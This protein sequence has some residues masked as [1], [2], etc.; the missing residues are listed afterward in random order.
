V[1]G[2]GF[3][4]SA[5]LKVW[6]RRALGEATSSR[7]KPSQT[8]C[9]DLKTV[10]LVD[11]MIRKISLALLLLSGW[12]GMTALAAE[13]DR[14]SRPDYSEVRELIQT[15]LPEV[16]AAQ[17]DDA[18]VRGL[19]EA[20][21]GK[22]RLVDASAGAA[23]G[24]TNQFT[25]QTIEPGVGLV[26]VHQLTTNL[27]AQLTARIRELGRTNELLG[28]VLDLRFASGEDYAAVAAVGDLF[29]TEARPLLD[30]GQGMVSGQAKNESLNFPVVVLVNGATSGAPEV[31]A[32]LLRELGV[33]LIL[34]SPTRGAVVTG[35]EFPL[36]NGQRLLVAGAPVKLGTGTEIASAGVTPDIRVS[37]NPA[38]ERLYWSDPFADPLAQMTATNGVGG[39]TN[40]VARRTRTSEADLV[41]ARREGL[42]IDSEAL[43]PQ[44]VEPEQPVILD[45]A[46]ARGVDVL[47]GLAVVRRVR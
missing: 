17:L 37:V 29:V 14:S 9:T 24:T 35:R 5:P 7:D 40:R 18:A 8:V 19:L 27:A 1:D 36:R 32:A 10:V 28:F 45:P 20:F 38:H 2:S 44:E 16:T 33:G 21:R 22:V 13:A 3:L 12:I 11:F 47:K 34:G 23:T 41:R 26:R 30:W 4:S 25:V 6:W 31:L 46:L 39:A 43:T 15:H 42:G